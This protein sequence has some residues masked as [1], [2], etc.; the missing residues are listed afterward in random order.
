[1]KNTLII[2]LLALILYPLQA[3]IKINGNYGNAKTGSVIIRK[4]FKRYFDKYK[5][6]GSIVVYDKTKN[7]WCYSDTSGVK[8]AC[9][10]AST[11]KIVNLL[12]ALETKAIPDIDTVIKWPG[13]ADT[14]KYGYRP[15]IY[16]DMSVKE[17][18]ELSA[19]WV[20]IELAKKIGKNAYRKYLTLCNYG[21]VNLSIPEDD[22][23]NFGPFAISPVNQAQF[24]N[25]LCD[26]KLPFSKKNM[27]IVKKVMITEKTDEFTIHSKT[28]WTRDNGINTGWWAGFVENK[29]GVYVFAICIQQD[30]K[31]DNPGFSR[32][33]KEITKAVLTD[34]GIIK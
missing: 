12:I 34:L 2:I 18:F 13:G 27:E 3:K 30:R 5:V 29:I 11:F 32:S 23:W 33:R 31:I 21:N 6:K 9:L 20:F 22:F 1:M 8:K 25:R 19:G 17:A 4:D 26:G 7:E 24:I 28:G 16:K 14:V 10:P 15:E